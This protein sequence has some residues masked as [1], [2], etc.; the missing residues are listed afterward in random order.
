MQG[1]SHALTGA[2]AW[3]T[4]TSGSAAALGWYEQPGQVALTGAVA[5]AG[6]A[7]LPDLDH[8]QGTIAWSLPPVKAGDLTLIPSPT[9]ALCSGVE[10]ISGGHRHGTHSLLGIAAFTAVAWAAS[11][12]QITV[13]GRAVAIGS[14]LFIVLLV[15]FAV[16]ALRISRNLS[17]GTGGRRSLVGGLLGSWL[18]PWLLAL[19]TAGVA[20]WVLGER[21]AWLP[22]AV[23][24]GALLHNL[25]DSLTVEGVPWLWPWNPKPPKALLKVPG[26]GGMVGWVWQGNGYFRLPL[27]G[28]TTSV[29]ETVFA[30]AVAVYTLYLVVFE[31]AALAGHRLLY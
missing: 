19:G 29:R 8:P 31:V 14:G 10:T 24:V 11:L 25:G 23:G 26:V 28:H 22:V 2:A 12:V 7:L 4:L 5:C 18:G 30:F 3:L 17:R 13:D 9:Q 20:T 15:A 21:W 27:L 16:K 1:Y 6:A